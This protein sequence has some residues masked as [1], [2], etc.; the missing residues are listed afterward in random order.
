M[1]SAISTFPWQ[2][3]LLTFSNSIQ[4]P[5]Q[6]FQVVQTSGHSDCRWTRCYVDAI[7][8]SRAA[9]EIL[10]GRRSLS[11]GVLRTRWCLP[12]SPDESAGDWASES[13]STMVV[14]SCIRFCRD[15]D[16]TSCARLS[17]VYAQN[18]NPFND[19][20]KPVP[21]KLTHTLPLWLQLNIFNKP[22]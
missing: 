1:K 14:S 6:V 7:R 11:S 8:L 2:N 17:A 18:S 13:I 9:A 3:F 19:P 22:N 10:P 16:R 15:R 5:W 4:I 20:D 21:E 12:G